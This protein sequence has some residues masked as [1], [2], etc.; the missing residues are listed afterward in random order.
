M[1]KAISRNVKKNYYLSHPKC[2]NLKVNYPKYLLLTAQCQQKP[3]ANKGSA[4]DAA[5]LLG[6]VWG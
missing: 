6:A 3:E 4:R 2:N 1:S 5:N